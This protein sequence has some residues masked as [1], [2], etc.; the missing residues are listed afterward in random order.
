MD[1]TFAP[2]D[3][4]V[5]KVA[6]SG[7]QFLDPDS[8]YTPGTRISI[9]LAQCLWQGMVL[10]EADFRAWVRE[11]RAEEFQGA[12]VAVHCSA[13]ALV[14]AWAFMLVAAALSTSAALVVHGTADDLERLMTQRAIDDKINPTDFMDAKVVVKGCGHHPIHPSF[15]AALTQKLTPVVGSL[16][17]GEPCSTVPVFKKAKS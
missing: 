12:Y 17:F 2:V 6:Q 3:S 4:I 7:I 13:D 8:F 9:D 1:F 15:H 11:L 10:R 16:M 14:P 5:N